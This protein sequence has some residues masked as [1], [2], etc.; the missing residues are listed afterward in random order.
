MDF[1]QGLAQVQGAVVDG[2]AGDDPHHALRGQGSTAAHVGQAGYATGH[3]GK[4][5]TEISRL[6]RGLKRDDNLADAY[7]QWLADAA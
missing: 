3:F 2:P 5:P 1:G 4:W 7:R 6:E